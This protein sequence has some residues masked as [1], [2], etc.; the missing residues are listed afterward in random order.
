[1]YVVEKKCTGGKAKRRAEKVRRR[2]R[3]KMGERAG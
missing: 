1:V 3:T 2:G